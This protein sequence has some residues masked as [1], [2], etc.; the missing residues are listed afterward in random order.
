MFDEKGEVAALISE[1]S[2]VEH[3]SPP[4]TPPTRTDTVT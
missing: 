2:S 1:G 3:E 4:P